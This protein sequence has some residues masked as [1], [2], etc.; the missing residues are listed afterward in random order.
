M[1]ATR[2]CLPGLP[3]IFIR[4]AT[5]SDADAVLRLVA[6]ANPDDPEAFE[7]ARPG[8]EHLPAGPLSRTANLVIL[9][10]DSTGTPLG[11]LMGGAPSWILEHPGVSHPILADYLIARIGII[12]AVA[13][14]PDRRGGGVGTALVR[15]AVRR[16]TRAGYGLLTLNFAPPLEGYYQRLGFTTMDNLIVHIG[17][18]VMLGQRWDDT[19]VA[20]KAL[21]QCTELA[22]VPGLDSPLVSGVLPRSRV[23][24]GTYFDGKQLRH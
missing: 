22:A 19:R 16:F 20:A 1:N 7:G 10:E 11:A 13:V 4:D 21:D 9:A 24:R 12:S 2:T 18:G 14:R 5:A 15:H 23:P 17:G 3:D 6:A 8:L